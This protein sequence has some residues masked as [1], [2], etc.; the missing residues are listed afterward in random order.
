MKCIE[1]AW[2]GREHYYPFGLTMAGISSKAANRLENKFEYNGK[3]KQ[4]QEFADGSGLDWYDYGARMY[5]A[6]IGRWHAIDPLSEATRRWSPFTYAYNN[7]LLFID[8]DGMWPYP[9][10]IR[11]W[12]ATPTVAGG[13]FRGDGRPPSTNVSPSTTS[14]V[15]QSYTVDPTK[16]T[17]T[18]NN[19]KHA[20]DD[21]VVCF[22][23][24]CSTSASR[25]A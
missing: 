15:T 1:M 22:N 18:D 3:E 5:D 2:C 19:G 9:V 23:V 25:T 11:S 24:G 8:P 16:G 10:S 21:H 7:P 17:V 4:E 13:A 20:T 12:I 14:R 6:Q